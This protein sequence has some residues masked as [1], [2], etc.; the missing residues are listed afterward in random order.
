MARPSED[1]ELDRH[2][3]AIPPPANES[4]ELPSSSSSWREVGSCRSSA[5]RCVIPSAGC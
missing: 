2:P 4:R 1:S 3:S 5:E